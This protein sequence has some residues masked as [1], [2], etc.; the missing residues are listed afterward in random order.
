MGAN[1]PKWTTYMTL[2]NRI[3]TVLAAAVLA[4]SM[5]GGVQAAPGD[6][7]SDTAAVTIIRGT[8]TATIAAEDFGSAPYSFANQTVTSGGLVLTISNETGSPLGWQVVT[9][10]SNYIGQTRATE[11][12][13]FGNTAISGT[14]TLAKVAGQEVGTGLTSTESL[15]SGGGTTPIISV[16]A[17]P[18]S[19]QGKYTLTLSQLSLTVPG[20]TLA[21]TYTSTLTVT[22]PSAP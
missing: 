6:L 8:F 14:S 7:A 1:A 11:N 17:A 20:G 18:G 15:S 3:A 10:A 16:V 9:T 21:Q 12:V 13:P 5:M 2:R 4:G 22:L 19:G